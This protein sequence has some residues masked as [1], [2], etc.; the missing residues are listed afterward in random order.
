MKNVMAFGGR[1]E[2]KDLNTRLKKKSRTKTFKLFNNPDS[3]KLKTC[4]MMPSIMFI[5]QKLTK[6]M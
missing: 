3:K 1:N 2:K 5:S 4:T 6:T